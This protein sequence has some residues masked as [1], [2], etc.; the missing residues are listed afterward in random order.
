MTGVPLHT[1]PLRK[2]P[3][4]TRVI[5]FFAVMVQLARFP[6]LSREKRGLLSRT[7]GSFQNLLGMQ[8]S[9]NF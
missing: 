5:A 3:R 2:Y 6:P 7:A 1:R 9:S 4:E 8:L